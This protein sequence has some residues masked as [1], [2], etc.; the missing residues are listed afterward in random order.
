MMNDEVI[1]FRHVAAHLRRVSPQ[2]KKTTRGAARQRIER[3][4]IA[5]RR[6]TLVVVILGAVA[7]PL[8]S[9]SLAE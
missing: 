4:S 5:V 3:T 9:S 2:S 1:R 6:R 7:V 8:H